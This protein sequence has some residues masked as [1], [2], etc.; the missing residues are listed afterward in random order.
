MK[1]T[2]TSKQDP[3]TNLMETAFLGGVEMQESR[4]QRQ[5]VQGESL[6]AECSNRDALE[7]PVAVTEEEDDISF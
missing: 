6:P 1:P 2:N 7:A 4:G 5:L 3:F